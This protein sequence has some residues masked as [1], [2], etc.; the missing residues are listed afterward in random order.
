M[1]KDLDNM[2]RLLLFLLLPIV[3]SLVW[4]TDVK[5]TRERGR[6]LIES[7]ANDSAISVYRE[8]LK[9]YRHGPE[10]AEDWV[11]V[12]NNLGYV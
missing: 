8:A 10:N 3:S 11:T 6:C 9:D 12:Y 2:R 1:A 4:A 7:G 5:E